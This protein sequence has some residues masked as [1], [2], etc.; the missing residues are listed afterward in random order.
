MSR[1]TISLALTLVVNATFFL[2]FV[3]LLLFRI[4]LS[5]TKPVRSQLFILTL[6]S[7]QR[8]EQVCSQ[9]RTFSSHNYTCTEYHSCSCCKTCPQSHILVGLNLS[10]TCTYAIIQTCYARPWPAWYT[11]ECLGI[12]WLILGPLRVIAE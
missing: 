4:T 9:S 6:P 3:Y 11:L 5:C 1:S 10:A 2:S 8:P 12:P 7:G